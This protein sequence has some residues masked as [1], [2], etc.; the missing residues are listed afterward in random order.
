MI[1]TLIRNGGRTGNK[2][3]QKENVQQMN[4]FS[5]KS[6]SERPAN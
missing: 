3:M 6:W 2:H 5:H 4:S 1:I